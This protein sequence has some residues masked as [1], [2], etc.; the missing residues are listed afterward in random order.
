MSLI[1]S[2]IDQYKLEYDFY[3]NLSQMAH[4]ICEN[5]L[6]S[7]GIKAIISSRAKKIDSLKDKLSKRNISKK[8]KNIDDIKNDIKDLSGVRIA[9][10]FPD[11]RESVDKLI[12]DN[13]NIVS[14]KIFPD[15]QT[16]YAPHYKKRFS[17][18]WAIHYRVKLSFPRFCGQAVKQY[19]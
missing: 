19:S 1:D 8:Y 15:P 2:F 16:T 3:G 9:L 7:A 17:G 11:E 14:T 12:K 18:Y 6:S 13:F 5:F 4:E 10:Y